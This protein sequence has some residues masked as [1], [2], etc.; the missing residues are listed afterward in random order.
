MIV[1]GLVFAALAAAV[2]IVIFY[3]ESCAWAGERARTLF[4]TG[5]AEEAEATRF[6]AF[7]QGFYNLFLA[8]LASIGVVATAAGASTAGVT[9]TLAGT[10]SMLAAA[11]VLFVSS[12]PHRS[13]AL[14]QGLLPLLAVVAL[15][16]GVT[17]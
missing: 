1:A 5:S 9:L 6:L 3:L 11:T 13:A 2:H 15:V 7:N 4:R 16:L 14:K 12:P 17:S 8:L 10:G